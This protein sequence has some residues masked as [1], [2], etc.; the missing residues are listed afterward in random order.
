MLFSVRQYCRS[1]LCAFLSLFAASPL[2]SDTSLNDSN[3]ARFG[4]AA[5][6]FIKKLKF[7]EHRDRP[8]ILIRCGAM[9]HLSGDIQGAFC[10]SGDTFG[11]EHRMRELIVRATR[12]TRITP[13]TINGDRSNVRINFSVI[14]EQNGDE[15]TIEILENHLYDIESLGPHYVA[16]QRVI[17]QYRL[18]CFDI[19]ELP[20]SATAKI[21]AQGQLQALQITKDPEEVQCAGE[22]ENKM[23]NSVFI[24][25][26][27]DGKA[28][29]ST[30]NE[31]FHHYLFDPYK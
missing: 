21:S 9:V 18:F 2:F 19:R 14:Y 24:P 4:Q 17:L 12:T 1:A 15:K 7:P 10:F 31:V 28:V 29:A 13:A 30:F 25:A 6:A 3:P 16:A 23:R 8:A 5:S 26:S 20:I 11:I 22:V 27:V